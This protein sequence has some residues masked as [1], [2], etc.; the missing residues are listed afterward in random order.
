MI[1]QLRFIYTYPYLIF[2]LG[3]C[4]IASLACSLLLENLKVGSLQKEV[5]HLREKY[6]TDV[7]QINKPVANTIIDAVQSNKD[8]DFEI[9]VTQ[10]YTVKTNSADKKDTNESNKKSD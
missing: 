10:T 2:L 9:A 8:Q 5:T 7:T 3:F 6:Q 1:P 4:V